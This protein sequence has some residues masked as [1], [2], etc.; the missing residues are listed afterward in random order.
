MYRYPK[1]FWIVSGFCVFIAMSVLFIPFDQIQ[2]LTGVSFLVFFF[3]T[4][5]VELVCACSIAYVF[6]KYRP[7]EEERNSEWTYHP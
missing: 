6:I 2:E 7:S 4:S 3:A 1:K 5:L